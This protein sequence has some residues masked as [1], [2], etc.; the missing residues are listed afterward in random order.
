MSRQSRL[1]RQG[2]YRTPAPT[3]KNPRY[4]PH[5]CQQH[6]HR[7]LRQTTIRALRRRVAVGRP[8]H[9]PQRLE[10]RHR[11]HRRLRRLRQKKNTY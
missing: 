4:A 5:R 9:H 8:C 2:P 10:R 7:L 3:K 6:C 11:V 1:H